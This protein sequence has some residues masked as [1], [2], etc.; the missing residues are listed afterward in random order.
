MTHDQRL[1]R[2]QQLR[3]LLAAGER[4]PVLQ[5]LFGVSV[6]TLKRLVRQTAM[7]VPTGRAGAP[8]RGWLGRDRQVVEHLLQRWLHDGLEK[9][10]VGEAPT[11]LDELARQ[12]GLGSV[13]AIAAMLQRIEVQQDDSHSRAGGA[14]VARIGACAQCQTPMVIVRRDGVQRSSLPQCGNPRCQ[15]SAAASARIVYVAEWRQRRR[16][17]ERGARS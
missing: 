15:R 9:L 5:H 7:S 17:H 6:R 12:A 10:L 4:G 11:W 1:V 8:R 2:D 14:A 3:M 16:Q 13:A